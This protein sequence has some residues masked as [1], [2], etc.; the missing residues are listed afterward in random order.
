MKK[1]ISAFLIALLTA[2]TMFTSCSKMGA[3]DASDVTVTPQPL[4][5]VGNE[6]PTLVSGRFKEKYFK[7]NAT[8][9]V[10]PVLRYQGGEAKGT[11]VSFQGESVKG[12]SQEVNYLLG[13]VFSLRDRFAY[14][15]ATFT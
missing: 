4:E 12:N 7:K 9:T 10:T 11:A 13:G 5:V 15:R 2:P 14:K 1:S 6:V 3:Y 8:L